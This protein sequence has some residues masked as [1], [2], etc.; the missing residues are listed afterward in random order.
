LTRIE[1]KLQNV[2][3]AESGIGKAQVTQSAYKQRSTH[4][5]NDG[6]SNLPGNMSRTP[7]GRERFNWAAS[8]LIADVISNFVVCH[9]GA[10]PKRIPAATEVAKQNASTLQPPG[11]AGFE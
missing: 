3:A 1:G 5:Q 7:N 11:A 6:K 9:A 10:S 8:F 2:I 4:Q